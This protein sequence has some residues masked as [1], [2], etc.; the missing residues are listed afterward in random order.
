MYRVMLATA[1]VGARNSPTV[2]FRGH[3]LGWS[4]VNGQRAPRAPRAPSRVKRDNTI[5][6]AHERVCN[7]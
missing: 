1:F 2:A 5:L 4:V 6:T 3:D 7:T